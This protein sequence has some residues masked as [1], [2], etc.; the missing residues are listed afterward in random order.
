MANTC[1]RMIFLQKFPKISDLNINTD[2][3]GE[4]RVQMR[5]DRK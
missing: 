2:V 1:T 5:A 3:T 4:T